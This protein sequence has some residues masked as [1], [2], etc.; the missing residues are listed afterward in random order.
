MIAPLTHFA[1]SSSGI[2]ALG[3]DVKDLVIQIITFLLAL[4][5][6]QHWAFKPILKLMD[7]RHKTIEKGVE[8]GQQMEKE[9]AELEAKV[10]EALHKARN[11]ADSIVTEAKSEARQV[12]QEAEDDA[13][14]KAEVLIK[15]A[16]EKIKQNTE[17]A[18]RGLEAEFADLI[19]EATEVIIGEKVDAKK[20]A[21]LMNRALKGR[22]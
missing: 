13:R 14:V 5:A 10:A 1:A 19:S 9:K 4:W 21:A 8:L 12:V 17:R 20:D 15:E 7:K 22:S 11:E 3:I 18:R 2:G 6:L 16:D